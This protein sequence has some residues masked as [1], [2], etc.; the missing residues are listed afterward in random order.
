M[1]DST[2]YIPI[3]QQVANQLK[4]SSSTKANVEAVGE[5]QGS[6][7]REPPLSSELLSRCFASISLVPSHLL[8][9][10]HFSMIVCLYLPHGN[11]ED[12][13]QTVQHTL[14][15]QLSDESLLFHS[16]TTQLWLFVPVHV[17]K[18][19]LTLALTLTLTLTLTT[20]NRSNNSE[21]IL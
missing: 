19:F 5:N 3:V 21:E 1:L 11:T 13:D 7:Q 6:D 12:K 20:L 17:F 2:F 16:V 4:V 15:I 10:H 9:H 8:L 18:V 14:I